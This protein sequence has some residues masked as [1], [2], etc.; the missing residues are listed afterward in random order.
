[1]KRSY[2]EMYQSLVG[3]QQDFIDASNAGKYDE[4]ERLAK[5]RMRIPTKNSEELKKMPKNWIGCA[6]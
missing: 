3:Y 5:D 1:M 6:R 2:L 4:A